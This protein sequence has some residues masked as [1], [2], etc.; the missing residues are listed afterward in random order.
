MTVIDNEKSVD[1]SVT[2][3]YCEVKHFLQYLLFIILCFSGSSLQ[4][5][6][7]QRNQTQTWRFAYFC[8]HHHPGFL[9]KTV[10]HFD[11]IKNLGK[12]TNYT[13]CKIHILE[14]SASLT[15]HACL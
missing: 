8:H 13:L 14:W 7:G 4:R 3:C 12:M 6:K 10:T 1:V 2:L 5:G 9:F 11:S 15:N